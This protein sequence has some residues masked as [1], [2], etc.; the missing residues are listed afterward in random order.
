M[1]RN[2]SHFVKLFTLFLIQR[3]KYLHRSTRQSP[4]DL[5]AFQ[6]LLPSPKLSQFLMNQDMSILIWTKI[7]ETW[8]SGRIKIWFLGNPTLFLDQ[9]KIFQ[10]CSIFIILMHYDIHYHQVHLVKW[11]IWMAVYGFYEVRRQKQTF[12]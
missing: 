9:I 5:L 12:R 7:K 3:L 8:K 11:I 6:N 2:T 10:T 1:N 4:V